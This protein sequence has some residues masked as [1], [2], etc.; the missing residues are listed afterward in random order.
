MDNTTHMNL[1]IEA[2][3][4]RFGKVIAVHLEDEEAHGD[5]YYVAC[6]RTAPA[7]TDRPYMSIT[8]KVNLEIPGKEVTFFSGH[9]D[10]GYSDMLKDIALHVER[11]RI[12]A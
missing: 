9:Y 11:S 1:I 2:A 10:M 6:R 8:G 3:T 12:A 4:K 7:D 5:F